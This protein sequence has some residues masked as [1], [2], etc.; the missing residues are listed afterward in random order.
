[1]RWRSAQLSLN[2]WRTEKLNPILHS[3]FATLGQEL[4]FLSVKWCGSLS[5]LLRSEIHPDF[6]VLS[7]GDNVVTIA[8]VTG[9]SEVFWVGS[10][11]SLNCSFPSE[12]FPTLSIEQNC[13]LRHICSSL[14]IVPVIFHVLFGRWTFLGLVV[15]CSP[16]ACAWWG[17][18][19][20]MSSCRVLREVNCFHGFLTYPLKTLKADEG[21]VRNRV[22]ILS[23]FSFG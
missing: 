10:V 1:M 19:L 4:S 15:S 6:W 14:V 22:C 3:S 7:C 16:R 8:L 2:L 20:C 17:P 23:C 21:G 13:I 9:C 11:P 18:S 12:M 5:L